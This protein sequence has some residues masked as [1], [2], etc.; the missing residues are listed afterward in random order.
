MNDDQTWHVPCKPEEILSERNH[1]RTV[2]RT[3]YLSHKFVEH[4]RY[5]NLF[6]ESR[7]KEKLH[8]KRFHMLQG[9]VFL[10]I[11]NAASS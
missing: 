3:V 5:T 9:L 4:Y 1:Y 8:G 2:I 11:Y 7:N 10:H 6:S